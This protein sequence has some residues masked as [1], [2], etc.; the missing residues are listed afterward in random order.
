MQLFQIYNY[1]CKPRVTYIA[2]THTRESS[3]MASFNFIMFSVNR[4][5]DA[6]ACIPIGCDLQRTLL[7]PGHDLQLQQHAVRKRDQIVRG[8]QWIN[9]VASPI[10]PYRLLPASSLSCPVSFMNDEQI[11]DPSALDSLS[12]LLSVVRPSIR[13]TKKILPEI[14]R[15]DVYVKFL[16]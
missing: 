10:Y 11:S 12:T 6:A 2:Q 16:C 7:Y 15:V 9:E 1:V 4:N 13:C 5:S 3:L 8:K 14:T